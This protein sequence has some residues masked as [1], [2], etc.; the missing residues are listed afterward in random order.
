M[1]ARGHR[2]AFVEPVLYDRQQHRDLVEDPPYAEV[3]VC[4][5]WSDLQRELER[6]GDADLVA[7]CSG[8]GGWDMELAEAVL[9]LQNV[10]TRVAFWDVDAPQTLASAFAEPVDTPGTFRALIPRYDLILLY[11]GGPPVEVA[12]ARLGARRTQLVY[13]AVD[14]DEYYPVEPDPARRCDLLF[15]GNRMPDREHRRRSRRPPA[16]DISHASSSHWRGSP[17]T[18]P[19]RTHL[20]RSRSRARCAPLITLQARY[21][22][23]RMTRSLVVFGLSLS[24]S[25]GN[26]HAPT[27]RGLLR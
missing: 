6:A 20:H 9:K 26:G 10:T 8:V 18:C 13:N 3:R 5:N 27:F 15:M 4:R 11:G 14:P 23:R 12:Y 22:S 21:R 25:W 17:P 2:V 16:P 19:P 24:S 7:K 1:H